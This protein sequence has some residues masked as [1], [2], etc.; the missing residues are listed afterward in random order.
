[1]AHR[2]KMLP[3]QVLEHATTFDLYAIDVSSR[4]Q[5]YLHDKANGNQTKSNIPSQAE[6]V[7]MIQRARGDE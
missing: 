1:M 6:M 2:Y 4:Y 7:K 3:S 5:Q